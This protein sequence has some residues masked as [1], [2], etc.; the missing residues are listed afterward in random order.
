MASLS[1]FSFQDT[2]ATKKIFQ[3]RK[4]IRA[5][6]GGTSASKTISILIWLIDYCQQQ[7][8]R[9][10]LCTVVSESFP[11]LE[12]GAIED[13]KQIMFD[14]RYWNDKLW[15]GTKHTYSFETGSRLQ[16][17]SIDRLGKAHGPRRDV[18]FVN[19]AN[20]LAYNIVDQLITRTREIVWLDWNPTSEFW[21]YTDMLGLRD[22]IDFITLTYK[23]N[24]ALDEVTI[25]EIESHKHLKNWWKVYG[26][27]QL[28][29]LEGKIYTNWKMI[30][31][32]PPEALLLKRGL[33]FGYSN[34]PTAGG[35]KY[36]WNDAFVLDEIVY[37]KGLTNKQISDVFNAQENPKTTI[38]ADSAEPKSI[39]ELR[40]EGLNVVAAMK[41][42]DSVNNGIQKVQQQNIFVTKRSINIWK[43]YRNYLWQTDKDGRILNDPQD[44]WNHHMDWIRYVSEEPVMPKWTAG[45][46]GGVKPMYPEL[47][48]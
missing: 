25:R 46:A 26:L 42:R 37:Q 11:H 24:E 39:Y 40:L 3:L 33:D 23:D 22:D 36:K 5:V 14:R 1:N 7:H 17:K 2:S 6:S 31:E 18:L 9:P 44:I 48:I 29:D 30:D 27:G 43:E 16:F 47:G 38:V 32:V 15:N 34:D 20:N 28:G 21:F 12:G 35:S 45:D 13:F 8:R 4:R 10:K 19:E 41:G